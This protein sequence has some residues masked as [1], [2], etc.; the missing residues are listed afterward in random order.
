MRE[1]ILALSTPTQIAMK[2]SRVLQNRARYIA[3]QRAQFKNP[4][5]AFFEI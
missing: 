5:A 3:M 4:N 2:G 1:R